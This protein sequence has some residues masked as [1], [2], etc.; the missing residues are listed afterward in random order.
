MS[1]SS[2]L[3]CRFRLAATGIVA[4]A[5]GGEY[6]AAQEKIRVLGWK[7]DGEGARRCCYGLP[8]KPSR[9]ISRRDP[10]VRISAPAFAARESASSQSTHPLF[11]MRHVLLSMMRSRQR[12]PPGETTSMDPVLSVASRDAWV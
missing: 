11:W 2:V 7:D 10:G 9:I 5:V 6:Q 1:R 8:R 12:S 3:D 4:R